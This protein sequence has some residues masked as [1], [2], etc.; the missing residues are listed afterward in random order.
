MEQKPKGSKEQVSSL[1]MVGRVRNS[2]VRRQTTLFGTILIAVTVLVIVTVIL[3]IVTIARFS[4]Q[5]AAWVI[6]FRNSAVFGGT[7]AVFLMRDQ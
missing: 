5:F 2:Y 7:P 3:D 6:Q 1:F 4:K